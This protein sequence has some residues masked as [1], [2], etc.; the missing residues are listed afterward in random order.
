MG[1]LRKKLIDLYIDHHIKTINVA[2]V[3]GIQ[4]KCPKK[5]CARHVFWYFI[6]MKEWFNSSSMQ[7]RKLWH[8]LKQSL[9]LQLNPPTCQDKRVTQGEDFLIAEMSDAASQSK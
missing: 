5:K 4:R 1:A 3:F 9:E 6:C 2:Y 8:T 7:V